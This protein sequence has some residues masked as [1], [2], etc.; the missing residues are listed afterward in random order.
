MVRKIEN[1]FLIAE[2]NDFGAELVSLKSKKTGTEYLWQGNPEYWK[3]RAPILFPICGRLYQGKYIYKNIEYEMT[4]HGIARFFEYRLTSFEENK[5]SLTLSSNEKTKE[6]YPFDFEFTVT[7]TLNERVL[8]TEFDIKNNGDCIM[9]FSYGG[10][11]GFNVPF[12]NNDC[13]DDYYVEFDK[14]KL[15]RMIFSDSHLYTENTEDYNL[16]NKKLHLHHHLFD[17]DGVFFEMKNGS[18]TLKSYKNDTTLEVS[19]ADMTCLGL[20]HK[21]KSDA[22]YVCIEPWH[23]VPSDDGKI[24][25]LSTKRQMISLNSNEKYTGSFSI[26]ITE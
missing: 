10:H 7:Y 24:D 11:P 25:D 23:G 1:E 13:F 4:I 9:P 21:P 26:K 12:T 6:S 3:G 8:K 5:I 2:I 17:N 22:P 16:D 15:K 14:D 19:F 20:W 18:A